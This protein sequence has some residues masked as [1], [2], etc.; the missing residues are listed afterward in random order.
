MGAEHIEAEFEGV[1]EPVAPLASGHLRRLLREVFG[2]FVI[3]SEHDRALAWEIAIQQPRADASPGCHLAERGRLIALLAN[4]ADGRLVETETS[5]L[6]FGRPP[7]WP[8][9]F[10]QLATFA[11]HVY[12]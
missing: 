12:H 8:A 6:S 11:E 1:D 3:Q 5:R 9:S 4:Q 7:L 2:E 10:S